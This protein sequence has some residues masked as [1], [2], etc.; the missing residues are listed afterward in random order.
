MAVRA[1]RADMALRCLRAGLFALVCTALALC[2]HVLAGGRAPAP[3]ILAAGFAGVTVAGVVGLGRERGFVPIAGGLLAG[4][5]GLHLL[6]MCSGGMPDAGRGAGSGPAALADALTCGAG[7]HPAGGH[8]ARIVRQAGLGAALVAHPSA[9]Q[10][11]G[12]LTMLGL[13]GWMIVA[14]VLAACLTGGYLW[15]G[16]SRLWALIR[17]AVHHARRRASPRRRT[18]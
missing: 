2:G 8:A 4:Q 16:E 18:G 14:H 1:D 6:F 17:L 3:L 9:G 10:H 7:V 13:S 12:T 15:F 11:A 5:F